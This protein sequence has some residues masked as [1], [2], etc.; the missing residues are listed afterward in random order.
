MEKNKRPIP[1]TCVILTI[2][3]GYDDL[4]DYALPILKEF[5]YPFTFYLYTNFLGGVEEL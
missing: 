4:Y 2:D 3:D 5:N 1:E